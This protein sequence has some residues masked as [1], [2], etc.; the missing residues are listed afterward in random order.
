M[1][2]SEG[3]TH[4]TLAGSIVLAGAGGAQLGDLFTMFK[5]APSKNLNKKFA[6]KCF[7]CKQ[8]GHSARNCPTDSDSTTT[9]KLRELTIE[10]PDI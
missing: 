9:A 8:K 7:K 10:K 4:E 1:P 3:Q 2:V 5:Q 6:G